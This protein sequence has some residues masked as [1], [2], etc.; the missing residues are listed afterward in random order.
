MY[1]YMY[2]YI[3]IVLIII[4]QCSKTSTAVLIEVNNTTYIVCQL[5]QE[6]KSLLGGQLD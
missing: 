3:Y 4:I 1:I 2:M 6:S 5:K